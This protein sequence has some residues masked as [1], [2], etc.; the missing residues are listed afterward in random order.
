MAETQSKRC[1]VDLLDDL[2]D[3]LGAHIRPRDLG[4][5]LLQLTVA[6]L[7]D[8]L[9]GLEGLQLFALLLDLQGRD[10]TEISRVLDRT[11]PVDDRQDGV[12]DHATCAGWLEEVRHRYDVALASGAGGGDGP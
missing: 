11:L 12:L 2:I 4:P 8:E 3:R 1:Q 6:A 7:I 5:L 10:E 9:P